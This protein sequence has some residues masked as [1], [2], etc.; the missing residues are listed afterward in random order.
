M[1]SQDRE[2]HERRHQKNRQESEEHHEEEEAPPELF[3]EEEEAP[4]EY[5]RNEEEEG[6]NYEEAEEGHNYEEA[7]EGEY[8]SRPVA[9]GKSAKKAIVHDP[10]EEAE[11]EEAPEM[12]EQAEEM[13]SRDDLFTNQMEEASL[14]YTSGP[15]S[16][17]VR[18]TLGQHNRYNS[19]FDPENPELSQ[20]EQHNLS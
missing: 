10:I 2:E 14:E 13:A 19:S 20:F 12:E 8:E 4:Q 16:K 18:K 9:K 11:A 15:T 17:S 7:E 5:N 1:S 3:A 6:D